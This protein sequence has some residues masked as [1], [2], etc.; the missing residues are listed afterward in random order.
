MSQQIIQLFV[1]CLWVMVPNQKYPNQEKPNTFK[2]N[3]WLTAMKW[4]KNYLH[5]TPRIQVHDFE[6]WTY[7]ELLINEN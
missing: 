5:V 6:I 4:L 7:F 1:N 2:D 3:P